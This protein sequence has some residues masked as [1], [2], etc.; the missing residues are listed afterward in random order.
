MILQT[1][2][3]PVLLHGGTV[4]T[5][6][7]TDRVFVGDVLLHHGRIAALGPTGSV[8]VTPGTRVLDV[9]GSIVCPG[10]VQSHVHL[11][12]VLFRGIAEDLS[13]LPWLQQRIWPLEAAHTAA[14]LRASARLGI[15]ELLLGGT[16]SILDMG[17]VHNHHVVFEAARAM[18]IRMTS[19]KA[20]MDKVGSSPLDE[21]TAAALSSSNHLADAWHRVDDDRLRYAYAPRFILS[22]TDELLQHTVV[23]ARARGCLVHT[24]A[25]ENPGE[26]DAVRAVTGRD[27][28][29]ALEDRGVAGKDVVLAH[30]VHLSPEERASLKNNGTRVAHCPST[31][32]KLASGTAPVPALLADGVTVGIGADGAPC[33]NRLS[34]FTEMRLAALLQKP[35]HGA[36]AMPAKLALRLMTMGSAAVLGR[37]GDTGSLEPG[38]RADVVVVGRERPHLRPFAD[39]TATL[40]HAAEAADVTHVFVDG[41]Q[42]VRDRRLVHDELGSILADAESAIGEVAARAGVPR[43]LP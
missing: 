1:D 24:H 40:V 18:G 9:T 7:A 17:T 10:F 2:P 8:R 20:M 29:T 39:P 43:G 21:P 15:A 32:L 35:L 5:V 22:C 16:T 19:G 38:K 23:E 13:L 14:T 6:D 33:N 31:N 4:V 37:D 27:N 36:E 42:L 11:C 41:R 12:Q 26:V 25:S 34:A 28:V 30:C 3:R